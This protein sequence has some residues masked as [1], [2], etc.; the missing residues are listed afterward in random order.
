VTNGSCVTW[1][2]SHHLDA[3]ELLIPLPLLLLLTIPLPGLVRPIGPLRHCI[4][5][6]E[7]APRPRPEDED[8]PPPCTERLPAGARCARWF[9]CGQSGERWRPRA[10]ASVARGA[11]ARS[12]LAELDDSEDRVTTPASSS[13]GR[14]ADGV[15]G[16]VK[17]DAGTFL[18][19]RVCSVDW[20]SPAW[21]TAKQE[22]LSCCC[23]GAA[24][25]STHSVAQES[26]AQAS[27]Q[28]ATGALPARA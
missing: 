26:R 9:R 5:R 19:A 13:G 3:T 6:Q 16:G 12:D 11:C 18:R 15:V 7:R 4:R 2:V 17:D 10:P 22:P 23:C 28:A 1:R 21:K 14:V 20:S 24:A 25:E 8:P 27:S